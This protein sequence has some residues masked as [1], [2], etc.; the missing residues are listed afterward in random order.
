M[1]NGSFD[2]LILLDCPKC[3]VVSDVLFFLL[4]LT[5]MFRG[6]LRFREKVV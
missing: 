3:N 4:R 6:G 5:D 1:G 2:Q